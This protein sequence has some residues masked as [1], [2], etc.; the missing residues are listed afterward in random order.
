MYFVSRFSCVFVHVSS[1]V[2]LFTSLCV[3]DASSVEHRQRRARE[4]E[5]DRQTHTHRER[6][7][8]NE[9]VMTTMCLFY[10]LYSFIHFVY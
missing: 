6:E 4:R 10:V 8:Q 3:D 2:D 7:A 1:M 9:A 5:T